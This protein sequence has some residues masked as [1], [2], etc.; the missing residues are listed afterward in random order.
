MFDGVRL[1]PTM[2]RIPDTL[3]IKLMRE[4]SLFDGAFVL[5]SLPFGFCRISQRD[6]KAIDVQRVLDVADCGN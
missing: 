1:S 4:G 6:W 5:F 3:I 2:P